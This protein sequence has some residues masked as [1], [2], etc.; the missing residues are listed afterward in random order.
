[1][2]LTLKIENVEIEHQLAEI[3]EQQKKDIEDV[4]IKAIKNYLD[5]AKKQKF[6]YN[7]K[8]VTKHMHVIHKDYD[9][10]DVD[11]IALQH[12]QNSAEYV[13]NQRREANK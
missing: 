12:I 11:D 5:S 6:I 2:M 13:H 9:A 7:K 8:N 10:D 1:M 4:A 3:A